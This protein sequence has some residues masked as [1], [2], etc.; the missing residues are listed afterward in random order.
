MVL[1]A[2]DSWLGQHHLQLQWRLL[3]A[4][5][6]LR[7]LAVIAS[8]LGLAIPD[9]A[10]WVLLL[11]RDRNPA[12]V[13]RL[14]QRERVGLSDSPLLQR[15]R[16]GQSDPEQQEFPPLAACEPFADL[17]PEGI[18]WIAHRGHL[19]ELEAGELVMANRAASDFL[20]LVLAGDVRLVTGNDQRLAACADFRQQRWRNGHDHRGV[21]QCKCVGRPWWSPVVCGASPAVRGSSAAIPPRW[22]GPS[23]S[24]GGEAGRPACLGRPVGHGGEHQVSRA[25]IGGQRHTADITDSQQCL[26]IRAVG[27]VAEGVGEKD[28]G[29]HQSRHNK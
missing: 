12:A 7:L 21:S 18:L 20:A 6:C 5:L 26:D 9:T 15:Q 8:P 25:G 10:G 2:A 16:L 1:V 19:Q 4:G 28:H 22:T 24:T 11:A 29:L 23:R 13:A 17:L 14:L 3:I 27:L